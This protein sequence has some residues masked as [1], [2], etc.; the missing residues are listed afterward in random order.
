MNSR[1]SSAD[2]DEDAASR[3]EAANA[4]SFFSTAFSLAFRL[5]LLWYP[6]LQIHGIP[7]PPLK[8]INKAEGK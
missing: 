8:R 5:I 6:L 2:S 7:Y 4:L 3:I 1:A